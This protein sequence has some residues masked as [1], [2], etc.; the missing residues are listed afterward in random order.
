M[1][2]RPYV[3]IGSSREALNVATV[4]QVGLQYDAETVIWNQ[5]LFQPGLGTLE[6]C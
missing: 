2:V 4:L 6:T 3:F 1:T 5:G